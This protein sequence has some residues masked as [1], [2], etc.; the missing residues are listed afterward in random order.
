VCV[1]GVIAEDELVGNLFLREPF[2]HELQNF[3]LPLRQQTGARGPA[4]W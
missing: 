1:D 4:R 3:P 2:D